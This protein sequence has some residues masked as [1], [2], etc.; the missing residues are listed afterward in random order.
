MNSTPILSTYTPI[1]CRSISSS[2]I[3]VLVPSP[4]SARSL[5]ATA[6]GTDGEVA[7]GGTWRIPFSWYDADWSRPYRFGFNAPTGL[8]YKVDGLP[9]KETG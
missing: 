8:Y 1:K 6:G 7:L 9:Y 2:F 4:A 5:P 3:S